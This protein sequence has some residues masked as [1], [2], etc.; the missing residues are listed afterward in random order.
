M[1][2]VG[3]PFWGLDVDDFWRRMEVCF[4]PVLAPQP[5]ERTTRPD[6]N[7]IPT[8]ALVPPPETWPNPEEFIHEDE[9]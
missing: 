4:R 8:I 2:Q 3:S 9:E 1:A 5:A 6:P 7:L